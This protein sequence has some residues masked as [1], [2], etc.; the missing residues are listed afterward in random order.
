MVLHKMM[1]VG[2]TIN[3]PKSNRSAWPTGRFGKFRLGTVPTLALPEGR[4]LFLDTFEFLILLDL[5]PS[6]WRGWGR[7]IR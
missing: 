1:G 5:L 6:F 2:C 4:E 3:F 7:T